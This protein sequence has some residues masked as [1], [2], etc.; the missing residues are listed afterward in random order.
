MRRI[1]VALAFAG[2]CA[3]C[4][5]AP[6]KAGL[7]AILDSSFG[8]KG[9]T[10]A[11]KSGQAINNSRFYLVKGRIGLISPA[12]QAE[13]SFAASASIT[14]GEWIDDRTVKSYRATLRFSGEAWAPLAD[15]QSENYLPSGT[16]VLIIA[17]YAGT[18]FDEEI[19]ATVPLLLVERVIRL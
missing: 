15:R 10:A 7:D 2:L 12:V 6:T 18:A 3:L 8:L 17:S 19:Q 1:I 4:F 16:M 13:K 5:P 11:V 9:L 14:D